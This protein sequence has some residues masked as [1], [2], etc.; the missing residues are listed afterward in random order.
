MKHGLFEV[1]T[2]LQGDGNW[3]SGDVSYTEACGRLIKAIGICT[4]EELSGLEPPDPD[5]SGYRIEPFAIYGAQKFAYRCGPDEYEPV[6]TQVLNNASEYMVTKVF[7][8]GET[9]VVGGW[10]GEVTLAHPD[11][12]TVTR[13]ADEAATL[14]NVMAAAYDRNPGI[15]PV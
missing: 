15:K 7:W 10:D 1:A 14:A 5:K 3:T 12:H 13:G 2:V 4:D 11:V 6:M 8:E 9:A